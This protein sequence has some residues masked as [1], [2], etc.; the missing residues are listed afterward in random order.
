[1]VSP[2]NLNLKHLRGV[3]AVR[4]H[5][6]I[7]AAA[8]MVNISQPALTQGLARLEKEIGVALFERRT[9]GLIA[10]D[11][12]NIVADRADMALQCLF[13]GVRGFTKVFGRPDLAL[14]MTQI[15][16]FLALCDTGS[17]V[18]AA[19][20]ADLS[21]SAIHRAV[22]ELED[23]LGSSLAERRGRGVWINAAGKRFARGARLAIAELASALA[24]STDVNEGEA[25]AIGALPLA[26][27]F[28]VPAALARFASEQPQT[29]FEVVEGNWRELIEP[30]RDGVVDMILGSLR[31][32]EIA[33]LQQTPIYSE[34]L[35]IA[36]GSE[37]PMAGSDSVTVEQLGQYPWIAPPITSPHRQD[38]ERLFVGRQLPVPPIETGSVMVIGRMLTEGNFLTLLSPSQIALQIRAGL[39]ATVGPPLAD[40]SRTIGIVTRQGWRPTRVQRRFLNL[41][42]SLGEEGIQFQSNSLAKRGWI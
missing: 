39:L 6:G 17:F 26:R 32:F 24:D 29:R 16:A 10:T 35:V 21:P 2:Y 13:K 38:W 42:T 3:V 27:P 41:L 22:R 34:C 4:Q 14:T 12:G 30:L 28:L 36:A 40:T 5:G 1:M 33:D 19:A 15:R 7:S 23:V 8:R 18:G 20:L 11:V 25:I 37:H 31:P 9:D